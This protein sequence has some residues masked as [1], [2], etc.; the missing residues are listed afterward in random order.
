MV[1]QGKEKSPLFSCEHCPMIWYHKLCQE[2]E[3]MNEKRI[4]TTILKRI[5][6]L[7]EEE[8]EQIMTKYQ[9]GT[10]DLYEVLICL[11]Y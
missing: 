5:D 2:L 1:K 9:G 7:G 10:E 11:F 8:E 6:Q 4:H 3:G